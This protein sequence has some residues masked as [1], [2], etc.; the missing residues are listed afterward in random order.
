MVTIKLKSARAE[1]HLELHDKITI[2]KGVSGS[3]KTQM[4]KIIEA[5]GS[6]YKVSIS[7]VRYRV[8]TLNAS[9]WEA[10]VRP[11]GGSEQRYI[12]FVDDADFVEQMDFSNLV[13]R[14]TTN[15]YVFIN[16]VSGM[17]SFNVD[18]IYKLDRSE[19]I[20]WVTPMYSLQYAHEVKSEDVVMT[21][22][23]TSGKRWWEEFLHRCE[24]SEG[25]P[26]IVTFMQKHKNQTI[27]M[28][29]DLFGLGYF[30]EDIL[31]A[32]V[33]LH[34]DLKFLKEYGSF[35]YLLLRSNMFRYSLTEDELLGS[36]SREI[37]C[38]KV[39]DKLTSGKYYKYEKD[40]NLNYCYYK[41]CC[42]RK[43]KDKCEL[44]LSG[45]K[46]EAILKGTEFEYLLSFRDNKSLGGTIQEKIKN[47]NL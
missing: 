2:I 25:N 27:V 11:N 13:K 12:Y 44:G 21:E 37:A 43:R 3:H 16:R 28:A 39:I 38:E 1:F 14:D 9:N 41:P 23:K 33:S 24:S 8:I 30:I 31:D 26:D 22:D 18:S 17:L 5:R 10:I 15:Y 34:V 29:V 46:F 35:E 32:A 7:D 20:H 40:Y 47:I 36:V 45:D 4:I 6:T 42:A 19:N